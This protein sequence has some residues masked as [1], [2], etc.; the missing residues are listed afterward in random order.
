[1]AELD[2]VTW[3]PIELDSVLSNT[4]RYTKKGNFY[5]VEETIHV[6]EHVAIYIGM[7]GVEMVPGP[8]AVLEGEPSSV[9][10]SITNKHQI[11]FVKNGNGYISELEKH[12]KLIV[13]PHPKIN[14]ATIV[15]GGYFGP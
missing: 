12:V 13:A 10:A 8:N 2:E 11:S 6:F 9:S 15:I 3:V 7:L 1:K 5:K 4:N 14:N